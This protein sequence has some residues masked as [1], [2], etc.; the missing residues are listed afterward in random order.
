[1]IFLIITVTERTYIPRAVVQ[2]LKVHSATEYMSRVLR[3][4]KV[5]HRTHNSQPWV[6]TSGQVNQVHTSQT[7]FPKIQFNIFP[8]YT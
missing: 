2:K 3:N 4:Q 7:Y 5:H 1:M 6:P 8:I